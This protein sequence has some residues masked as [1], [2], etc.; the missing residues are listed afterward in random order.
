[1]FYNAYKAWSKNFGKEEGNSE[2]TRRY[3]K[4]VS[5]YEKRWCNENDLDFKVTREVRIVIAD[6]KLRLK[7][8]NIYSDNINKSFDFAR[9]KEALFYFNVLLVYCRLSLQALSTEISSNVG[10]IITRRSRK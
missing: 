6:L 1:L 10:F 9:D 5:D 4:S 3:N 2:F 8:L 7:K